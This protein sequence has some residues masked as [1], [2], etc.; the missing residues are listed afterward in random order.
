[1]KAV[2]IERFGGPEVLRMG[3]RPRPTPRSDEVLLEVR[4]TSINPR[5]WL[6]RSGRY[7]FQAL[8]PRLPFILGSDV[9][10]TVVECGEKVEGLEPG[11]AVFA[12]QPTSRGFGACAEYMA[13]PATAVARKPEGLSFEEAAGI[14]L[15]GL[16][17]FQALRVHGRLEHGRLEHGRLEQGRLEQGCLEQGQTV[18]VIGASGGV[19][20]YAVQI[21]RALGARVSGVCSGRNREM[22]EGLGAERVIDYERESF[23]DGKEHYQVVFDVIG[24]ERLARCAHLLAPSGVYVTTIPRPREFFAWGKSKIRSVLTKNARRSEVVLVRSRGEDL[25]QLARWAEEGRLRTVIDRVYPLE[26]VAAAH[27][28]S[29]TFRTRGKLILRVRE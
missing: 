19:G 16:T 26:E 8:L 2:F 24:K 9:A 22:V 23:L 1:M 18:L 3:E 10:G 28:H 20:T 17:A 11:D 6:I 5:D 25:K 14:P 29:R 4:A 21:A 7:P 27:E 13:V 12:M 15:A